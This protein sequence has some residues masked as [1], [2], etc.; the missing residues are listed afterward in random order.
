MLGRLRMCV[1]SCIQEYENLAGEIFGH[2][3]IA[4]ILGPI[5]WPR[6]KYDGTI[7]QSSVQKVI[8]RHTSPKQRELGGTNFN[9]P[10]GAC[11]T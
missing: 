3:R 8:N 2:P 7:I 1:D 4:S 10:P 9:T 6:E 11:R 5:P